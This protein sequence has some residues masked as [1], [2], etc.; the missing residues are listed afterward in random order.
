MCA[1]ILG[2]F[3]LGEIDNESANIVKS[4][5]ITCRAL[6]SRFTSLNLNFLTCNT[7]WAI[8]GEGEPL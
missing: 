2:N 6:V 3:G 5:N 1:N 4:L 7:H 8:L